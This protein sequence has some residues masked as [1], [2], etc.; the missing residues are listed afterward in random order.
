MYKNKF[1]SLKRAAEKNYYSEQIQAA[2]N[3]LKEMWRIIKIAIN[4]T[5]SNSS[6]PDSFKNGNVKM[7]S[8]DEI[9]N[10]F[11]EYFSTIG[12]K[13][14]EKIW[15]YQNTTFDSFLKNEIGNSFFLLPPSIA[16]IT[17]IVDQFKSK[18]VVGGMK[19]Q[20]R[21]SNWQLTILLL[22]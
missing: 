15:P 11:N 3:N 9:S 6:V 10:K 19:F 17:S 8:N 13:L 12:P 18:K 20:C 2:K 14:D 1:T 16:E 7:T 22:Y 4:K 21:L 5:G